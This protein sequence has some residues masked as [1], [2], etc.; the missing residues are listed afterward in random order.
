V[1]FWEAVFAAVAM[2]FAVLLWKPKKRRTC[3]K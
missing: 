1:R 2:L 3:V